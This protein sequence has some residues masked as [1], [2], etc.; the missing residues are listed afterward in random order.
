MCAE[1]SSLHYYSQ[2]S[3]DSI[4]SP[5]VLEFSFFSPVVINQVCKNFFRRVESDSHSPPTLYHN[6]QHTNCRCQT[7]CETNLSKFKCSLN[8]APESH[9][10]GAS[11][12]REDNALKT[13]KTQLFDKVPIRSS[14]D[15]GPPIPKKPQVIPKKINR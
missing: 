15:V 5:V 11:L 13:C 7:D 14:Y 8:N 1:L 12:S 2:E 4:F 6:S 3:L 10:V 9:E